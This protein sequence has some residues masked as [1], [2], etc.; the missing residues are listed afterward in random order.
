M[1]NRIATLLANYKV[2]DVV[3]KIEVQ[4][5]EENFEKEITSQIKQMQERRRAVINEIMQTLGRGGQSILC[6]ITNKTLS[7]LTRYKTE[8]DVPEDVILKIE[9]FFRNLPWNCFLIKHQIE[10]INSGESSNEFNCS[11]I[12]AFSA[13]DIA[14]LPNFHEEI[15]LFFP[16]VLQKL[17]VGSA[18]ARDLLNNNSFTQNIENIRFV[19]SNEALLAPEIDKGDI[20]FFNLQHGKFSGD[21]VYLLAFDNALIIRRVQKISAEQYRLSCNS[22]KYLPIEPPA[23]DLFFI[24]KIFK[25]LPLGVAKDIL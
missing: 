11:V 9:Y 5:N 1:L 22:E 13:D 6:K 3:D 17:V 10:K 16:L 14:D 15:E 8:Y 25:A 12:N 7:Q 19:V 21:G 20:A 23:K 2:G 24:G 4:L 18:T